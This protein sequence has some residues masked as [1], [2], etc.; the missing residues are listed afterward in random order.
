MTRELR[1]AELGVICLKRSWNFSAKARRFAEPVAT[2]SRPRCSSEAPDSTLGRQANGDGYLLPEGST[3]HITWGLGYLP[4]QNIMLSGP[5]DVHRP[6]H[7][8]LV[9]RIAA[10]NGCRVFPYFGLSKG[11]RF[12]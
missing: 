11:E 12:A 6:V 3:I 8:S 2:Y 9:V 7:R 10:K 5:R 1:I 4:L